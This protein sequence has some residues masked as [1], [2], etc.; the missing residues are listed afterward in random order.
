MSTHVNPPPSRFTSYQHKAPS[1]NRAEMSIPP[2][3]YRDHQPAMANGWYSL[4]RTINMVQPTE[5]SFQLSGRSDPAQPDAGAL[6]RNETAVNDFAT[7]H[8]GKRIKLTHSNS[9]PDGSAPQKELTHQ[10]LE[11]ATDVWAY[12]ATPN[13]QQKDPQKKPMQTMEACA[14]SS[15]TPQRRAPTAQMLPFNSNAEVTTSPFILGTSTM[16]HLGPDATSINMEVLLPATT[17]SSLPTPSILPSTPTILPTQSTP[18]NCI[19]TT[20]TP[21]IQ[22]TPA[23]ATAPS[24]PTDPSLAAHVK[25]TKL[26]SP[27]KQRTNG[28]KKRQQKQSSSSSSSVPIPEPVPAEKRGRGRPRTQVEE[29]SLEGKRQQRPPTLPSTPTARKAPPKQS[30][31]SASAPSNRARQQQQAVTLNKHSDRTPLLCSEE[32]RLW[33]GRGD[34]VASLLHFDKKPVTTHSEP[35]RIC[36]NH[37]AHQDP[38]EPHGHSVCTT[39]LQAGRRF[40]RATRPELFSPAWWPLCKTCGDHELLY[41]DPKREGCSCSKAWLC[42]PCYTHEI[43]RRS[44]KNSVEAEFRRR[45]IIGSGIHGGIETVTTG[46]ACD[47]GR[48]IGPDATMM[49][50]IGCDGIRFDKLDPGEITAREKALTKNALAWSC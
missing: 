41:T 19:S 5:D 45:T 29:Q 50:C 2:G 15:F 44:M 34:H 9:Y 42:F 21:K 12:L 28:V 48:E 23:P 13:F 43:E 8:Q 4:K 35:I 18:N 26:L 36:T 22:L 30:N 37:A 38:H 40:L 7:K 31:S 32:P 16:R 27:V 39:C 47:C 24:A 1:S 46:W 20:Q 10:G 17:L 25:N 6:P 14:P 11:E 33:P 49:V 3:S